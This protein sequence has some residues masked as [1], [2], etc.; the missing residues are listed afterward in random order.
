MTNKINGVDSRLGPI[1]ASQPVARSRENTLNEPASGESRSGVQI[2]D[3]A[4]Q[5]A[6]LEKAIAAAP[7][8]DDARVSAVARAI[9]EGRYTVQPGR[10]A[11]KLL[12][13][14][15]ELAGTLR[16]EK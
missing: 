12:R 14:D 16:P 9:D 10:I 7:V 1:G 15:Q 13:M 3:G 2:T 5:L 6:A 8:V 4:R 11:D